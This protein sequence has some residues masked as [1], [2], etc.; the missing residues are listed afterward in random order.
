MA[1]LVWEVT[2]IDPGSSWTW[3]QRAPGS[4]VTARHHVTAQ[5]GGGTLVRQEL[6]QAGALGAL[7]GRLM[8][9]KTRRFLQLEAQGLKARSEQLSRA[10]GAHS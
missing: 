10:D 1:K 5:P 9:K 6:D 3:V 4:V 2:E 8:T 7:V